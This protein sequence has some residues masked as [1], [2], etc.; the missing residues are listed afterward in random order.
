MFDNANK[1]PEPREQGETA[2][3]HTT[4]Y[5]CLGCQAAVALNK[6]FHKSYLSSIVRV[7]GVTVKLGYRNIWCYIFYS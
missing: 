5:R 6:I 7:L 4:I 3:N 1:F 2:N